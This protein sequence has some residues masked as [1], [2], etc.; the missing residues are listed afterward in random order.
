MIRRIRRRRHRRFARFRW[1]A[2]ALFLSANALFYRAFSPHSRFA[3]PAFVPVLEATFAAPVRPAVERRLSRPVYPYSVIRGGAYSVAELDAALGKDLVASAHYAGFDRAGFDRAGFH[4]AGFHLD[5]LRMTT[6]PGPL[7]M[8]ASYRLGGSVYWT[9]HPVHI[10]AGESLITDGTSLA[11]ARCGNRLSE[12]PRKPVASAEPPEKAMETPEESDLNEA[13]APDTGALE[14][15][16]ALRPPIPPPVSALAF[17]V[18]P[19]APLSPAPLSSAPASAS[20]GSPGAPPFQAAASSPPV[21]W[22]HGSSPFLPAPPP[23]SSPPVE[24]SPAPAG[25]PSESSVQL[26]LQTFQQKTVSTVWKVPQVSLPVLPGVITGVERFS[27]DDPPDPSPPVT[28]TSRLPPVT[29]NPDPGGPLSPYENPNASPPGTNIVPEPAAGALLCAGVA[30][31]F[32][33]KRRRP[34]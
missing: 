22:N 17:E 31:L 6:A 1:F 19:P 23:P 14:R 9:S 8:F 18:F 16:L 10:A 15:L 13:P 34:L 11:R 32:I 7:L 26:T 24:N 4:L 3:P 2:F 33:A 27:G 20:P 29:G 21:A 28:T 25:E 30:F 5:S 12:S